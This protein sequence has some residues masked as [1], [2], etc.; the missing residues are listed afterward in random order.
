LNNMDGLGI[1]K[2]ICAL[3]LAIAGG[4]GIQKGRQAPMGYKFRGIE[5]FDNILCGLSAEHQ[6]AMYPRILSKELRDG[7]TEKG[8]YQSHAILEIEWTLVSA[9]DGS[10]QVTS[11]VG[12]AM[13]TQDKALNKAMQAS[14][15]YAIL[16]VLMIPTAGDDTEIY[17]PEP[18]AAAQ[19]AVPRGFGADENAAPGV[20]LAAAAT[21]PADTAKRTR[22]PNKP[23][24]APA[25]ELPRGDLQ[26]VQQ[27]QAEPTPANY[28]LTQ[29]RTVD[30]PA[31]MPF[32]NGNGVAPP[33]QQNGATAAVSRINTTN[34]FAIL[35]AF[36][37]DADQ[38]FGGNH[39][40]RKF[41]FDAIKSR[42]IALFASAPDMKGVQEGLELV[43]ALGQPDDLKQAANLAYGKFRK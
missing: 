19:Q 6:I 31:E 12:E 37:Q 29:A 39:P 35:Y 9:L 28:P 26:P 5:D 20:Q 10:K 14:R 36:A 40:D 43:T 1:H 32:P 17:V 22:G 25:Q 11:T 21:Q 33:Q 15:K 16:M 23:K 3:K 42:A 30:V 4:G 41:V 34:T 2:A 8:K 27:T 18:A 24:E 13:D 38:H 7:T